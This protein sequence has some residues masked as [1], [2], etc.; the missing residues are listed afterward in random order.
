MNKIEVI[1]LVEKL[2]L[3]KGEYSICSTGS[4]VIREIYSEAHDLDL[5][6]T[7]ECFEDIKNSDIK[8]HFKDVNHEYSHPLYNMDDY[9]VDFFVMPKE[10]IKFDYVEGYPC[11]DVNE[12]LDFKKKRN[13]PK[14]QEPIRLIEE[15]LEKKEN[16]MKETYE[17]LKNCGVFYIAT[18]DGDKPRVRPFGA[19]NIYNDK[20]YLQTGK[21]K[22]VSK[23]I[24]INNNIEICSFKDGKWIRVSAK[25]I[26]DDSIEA[27]T[28]MLDNN[29]ELKSMYSAADDNTEVSY[30][31][32]VTATI[33][34]FTEAP[35]IY[36][37]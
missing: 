19:L 34:S 20:L 13:L 10:E 26:R 33:S 32:D 2:N 18:I 21:I 8:Y 4:L 24:E 3:K 14:D 12:I 6:M 22:N 17:F 36:N 27:K 31:E 23:Q 29:P 16:N 5:Q 30:L 15:Y 9:D 37:F 28:S 1:N 7:N 35:T 25:A 11:Q